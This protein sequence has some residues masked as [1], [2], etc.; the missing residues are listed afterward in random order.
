MNIPKLFIIHY[1]E[2]DPFRCTAEKLRRFNL[3]S[4]KVKRNRGILLDPMATTLISKEDISIVLREGLVA[5]DISW[6]NVFMHFHR[7]RWSK[8]KR[9]SLP[10]LFAA[11]PTNYAKP[12]KLST[13]EAL[14][15]ALYILGFKTE[16]SNLLS[17]FK[18]MNTYF[19]LNK[20]Y[21][22]IYAECKCSEDIQTAQSDIV[23]SYY[24]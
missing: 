7:I 9:R 15:S 23:K 13:V 20:K 24:S 10:L 19:M 17:K 2:D 6:K 16:A 3:V 1:H 8:T 21:L 22:E 12:Y 11:N 4:F 18:W 5:L 14:A